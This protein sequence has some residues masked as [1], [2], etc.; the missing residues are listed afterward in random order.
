M[1]PLSVFTAVVPTAVILGAV[2]VGVRHT[3]QRRRR[4]IDD[5]NCNIDALGE[6]VAAAIRVP[7]Q[8]AQ[9][10]SGDGVVVPFPGP[11]AVPSIL[12][13]PHRAPTPKRRPVRQLARLVWTWS[14]RLLTGA[15]TATVVLFLATTYGSP[16]TPGDHLRVL[17][18]A[19]GA[20][21]P[22]PVVDDAKPSSRTPAAGP[23]APTSPTPTPAPAPPLVTPPP[24]T[25][26]PAPAPAPVAPTQAPTPTTTAPAPTTPTQAPAT[27]T[28]TPP[29]PLT[30]TPSIPPAQAD[31]K[32]H[33]DH[34]V[35]REA[36]V[37]ELHVLM[38]NVNLLC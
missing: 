13:V 33:D 36:C 24:T 23:P 6:V 26:A 31:G 19:A 29:P 37:A 35:R 18:P 9:R 11:P 12:R 17:P 25:P 2:A 4:E 21:N 5:V 10:A 22:N 32:P 8:R 27:S 20:T 15:C 34:A 1:S 7:A 16:P 38:L 14:P 28:T 3:N 30:T